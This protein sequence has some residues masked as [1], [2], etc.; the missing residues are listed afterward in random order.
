MRLRERLPGGSLLAVFIRTG[1]AGGPPFDCPMPDM[2]SLCAPQRWQW[3][4]EPPL[5]VPHPS[6]LVEQGYVLRRR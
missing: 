3:P 6:G 2:R 5:E 1:Q 4:D